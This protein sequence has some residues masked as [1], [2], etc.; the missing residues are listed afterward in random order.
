[1]VA[2]TAECKGGPLTLGKIGGELETYDEDQAD[3]DGEDGPLPAPK[4]G[5][6]TPAG[7]EA[8]D[9]ANGNAENAVGDNYF[10]VLVAG[11]LDAIQEIGDPDSPAS[12]KLTA[13]P[14]VKDADNR[15]A[16]AKPAAKT[17]NVGAIDRNGTTVQ[18]TYLTTNIEVDQRLVLVNR[19]GDEASFW[20]EDFNTETG[21]TQTNDLGLDEGL[22]ISANGRVVLKTTDVID[23]VGQQRGSATLNVAAPTRN[24]D[25]MTIQRSPATGEIDTTLYE[26][27]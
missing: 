19:G 8:A 9:K 16:A 13:H 6:L 25:V 14:Q 21:T 11:N 26:A 24:I 18:L 7:I 3:P 4:K 2:A 23:F 10:C 12:Y 15:P 17:M 1:M 22:T 20:V 5:D 27:M